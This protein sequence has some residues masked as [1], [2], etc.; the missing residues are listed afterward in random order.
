MD[1]ET[2]Q[3]LLE[4]ARALNEELEVKTETI[5]KNVLTDKSIEDEEAI[6]KEEYEQKLNVKPEK[7]ENISFEK[8]FGCIKCDKKFKD[9]GKET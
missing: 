5:G 6:I 1:D 7:D 8:P 3:E 4:I 2:T 9:K